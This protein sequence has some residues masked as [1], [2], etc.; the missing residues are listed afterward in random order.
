M[1]KLRKHFQDM[2][3]MQNKCK[4]HLLLERIYNDYQHLTQTHQ[5]RRLYQNLILIKK[6]PL[7]SHECFENSF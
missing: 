1:E 7:M 2:K 4:N 6:Y 5:G 3:I